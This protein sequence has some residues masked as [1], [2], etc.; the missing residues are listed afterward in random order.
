MQGCIYPLTIILLRLEKGDEIGRTDLP[1]VCL[2][3]R[4]EAAEDLRTRTSQRQGTP[5]RT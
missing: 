4:V 3:K 1:P 5:V 2:I